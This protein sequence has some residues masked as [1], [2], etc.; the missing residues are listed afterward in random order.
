VAFGQRAGLVGEDL[1]RDVVRGPVRERPGGVGA[2]AH[3]D[4]PL[5]R[6]RQGGAIRARRD[7]HE[8]VERR[9]RVLDRLAVDR[10]GFVTALDHAPGDELGDGRCPTLQGI[11]ERREPERQACH[12]PAAEA[13]LR[14]RRDVMDGLPVDLRRLADR[15]RQ[16]PARRQLAGRG[17]GHRVALGRQLAERRER[18][19]LATA[20][21]VDLIEDTVEGGF[22]DDGHDQDVGR[23]VPRLLGD[24]TNAHLGVV[25]QWDVERHGEPRWR[26]VWAWQV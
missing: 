22:A 25:L 13:S 2:L 23:H 9:G 3:D 18:P 20:P 15:D 5:G 6:P 10:P 16:Q 12:R 26:Q 21:P 14:G 19:E 24:D 11:R 8:F 17:Q 1:R 7:Q 4:A